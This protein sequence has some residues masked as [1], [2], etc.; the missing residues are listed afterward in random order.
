MEAAESPLLPGTTP[1][2]A[3][4]EASLAPVGSGRRASKAGR[5][6]VGAERVMQSRKVSNV[7]DQVLQLFKL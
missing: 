6:A 2:G 7:H 3:V 1:A 4:E 5:A